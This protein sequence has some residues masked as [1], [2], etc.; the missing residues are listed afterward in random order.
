MTAG[1]VRTAV[2]RAF[3]AGNRERLL[4]EYLSSIAPISPDIAWKHVYRL[5]LWIDSTTNLAH[6]YESDKS[7]PG[8]PWYERSLRF[9]RW[10]AAS[11]AAAPEDLR[12][13][14]D[15][16]FKRVSRDLAAGAS[17]GR[18]ERAS[19]QRART[20]GMPEPGRDPELENL[21]LGALAP[22]LQE[23][24]PPSAMRE[25]TDRI[26]QHT[27]LENK[28]KNLVGEGFED[29]LAV[30][31]RLLPASNTRLVRARCPLHDIPG[32]YEP[33]DREK[34][35]IVD[36][37]I[38]RDP[39]G[40]RSLVTAKW[41]IR[42]D[43]EEQFV[44]D[45]ASYV[46]LERAGQP[47]DYVLITNEFDPARLVAAAE[48]QREGNPLFTNV[49]HVSTDALKTVYGNGPSRSFARALGHVQSG[50]IVSL[51]DWLSGLQG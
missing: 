23:P 3:G 14:I 39:A 20:P 4:R 51:G 17:A 25:L 38:V 8:R 36:L 5:L 16:L 12:S 22:W 48:R 50:R 34:P 6:C 18:Q 30:L 27:R 44:S 45:C 11:L 21:I 19:N 49:V 7:Q 37:A 28:R 40:R 42:A 35:R 26:H 9:H 15:W 13:E 33:R 10:V 31:I 24:P 46:H 29:V 43:R 47:F 2:T 1:T 32:F 41:S